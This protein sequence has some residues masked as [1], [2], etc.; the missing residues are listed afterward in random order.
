M[1]RIIEMLA[2]NQAKLEADREEMIARMDANTKATLAT[3]VKMNEIK[4]DM[5]TMQKRAAVER[6]SDREEM[7]QV[8]RAGHEQIQENLKRMMEEMM[9][10]NQAKRDVKLEEL[11]EAIEKTRVEREEPTSAD[12]KAC[13]ETTACR[14]AMET[15]LKKME[16]N[17][18]EKEAAVERQETPKM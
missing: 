7:K 12:R 15:N 17:P 10:A 8:T 1:Q 16:L 4:E 11:G 5:K 18:G 14:D 13:Q 2:T 3:Q 6:K 9:S